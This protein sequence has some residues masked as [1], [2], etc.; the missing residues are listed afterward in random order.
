MF[1]V[2]FKQDKHGMHSD[3]NTPKKTT[4]AQHACI[5]MFV[6]TYTMHNAL[7]ATKTIKVSLLFIASARTLRTGIDRARCL[8]VFLTVSYL[9]I[10]NA[11]NACVRCAVRRGTSAK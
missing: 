3:I 10:Y 4:S 1:A 8:C 2:Q 7:S 6:P 11:P 5:C 9:H